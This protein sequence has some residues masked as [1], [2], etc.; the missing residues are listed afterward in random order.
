MAGQRADECVGLLGGQDQRGR[1]AEHVGAGGV[2]DESGG[3]RRRGVCADRSSVQHD[4]QQQAGAAD[5]VDQRVVEALDGGGDVL[6]QGVDVVEQSSRLDGV[7][8]GQ[9]RGRTDR[10][11]GEG[12]SVLAGGRAAAAG[13][14]PITA[15]IGRP[16][17]R[18]L[19]SVTTSGRI[20]ARWCANHAP[21]R[22]MPVCTSSRTSSAPAALVIS[23]AAAR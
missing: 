15:P 23:R 8:H 2:D 3:H 21:V 6:A 22:P 1:Q 5:L 14:K 11:A 19:A 20:P 17:P 4:A 12:G 13:P 16:P 10:V 18:P 7:E 9:S